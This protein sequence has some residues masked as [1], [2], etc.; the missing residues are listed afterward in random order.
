MSF[1]NDSL[2][3]KYYRADNAESYE[4]ARQGSPKWKFEEDAL[5]NA[6]ATIRP[7]IHTALDAPVGT[8]RFLQLY[9]HYKL[10]S[11]YGLDYSEDMLNVASRKQYSNVTLFRHDIIRDPLPFIADIV[12]CFR[13]LNLIPPADSTQAIYHLLSAAKKASVISVRTVDADYKGPTFIENKLYL[14]PKVAIEDAIAANGFIVEAVFDYADD[15][16]GQYGVWFC[17]KR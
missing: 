16:E 14:Q 17:L 11:V 8:G 12:V 10:H 4:R 3:K 13:F 1:E 15:K 5:S 2:V 9:S 7:S 6:I